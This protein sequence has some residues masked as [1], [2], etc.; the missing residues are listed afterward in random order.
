MY[1]CNTCQNFYCAN[2]VTV[3]TTEVTIAFSKAVTLANQDKVCF[4]LCQSI[5]DTAAGLPVVLSINGTTVPLWNK[6]GN[7]IIGA[8]LKTRFLYKGFYGDSTP[9]VILI[10]TPYSCGC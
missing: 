5:P 3:G 10:N 7:P 4:R 2:S 1:Q 6:Y 8:N 9:H